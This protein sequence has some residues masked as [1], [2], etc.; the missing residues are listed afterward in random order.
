MKLNGQSKSSNI[1]LPI[2]SRLPWANKTMKMVIQ[3]VQQK[4]GIV[5]ATHVA[6]KGG[7]VGRTGKRVIRGGDHDDREVRGHHGE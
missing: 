6:R 4:G 3:R 2:P 1:I 7:G 5:L